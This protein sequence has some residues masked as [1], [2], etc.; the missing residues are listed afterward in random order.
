MDPVRPLKK[1]R[2]FS[3]GHVDLILGRQRPLSPTFSNGFPRIISNL[4][5]L[6]E[7]VRTPPDIEGSTNWTILTTPPSPPSDDEVTEPFTS[8]LHRWSLRFSVH[9]TLIALFET[10]FFWVFVSKKEDAS[11][12]GLVND[13]AGELLSQ[14]D[15][16]NTSQRIVF[17]DIVDQFIN[18]T[19]VASQ[20]AAAAA[21][22]GLANG[23]LLTNS[24]VY[25]GSLVVLTGGLAAGA[26]YRRLPV[27]WRQLVYENLCL[28]IVL[29]IYEYM[30]FSTVVYPYQSISQPELDRMLLTEIDVSCSP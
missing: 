28:I 4:Q 10:L 1:N 12:I 11:L 26:K 7:D 30:F 19:Q 23:A 17:M 29:G 2:S 25:F 20:G 8:F 21:A 9:V 6:I 22:R 15:S 16:M 13:Y 14:C 24:W 18:Q 27:H 5:N 3:E